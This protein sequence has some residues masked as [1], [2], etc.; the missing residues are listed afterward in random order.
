MD[1]SALEGVNLAC[2]LCD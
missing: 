2:H 1:D